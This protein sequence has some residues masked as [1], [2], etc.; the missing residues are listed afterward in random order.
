MVVST[1]T[2][3]ID[4]VGTIQRFLQLPGAIAAAAAASSSSPSSSLVLPINVLP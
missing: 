4:S 2:I 3:L 1:T